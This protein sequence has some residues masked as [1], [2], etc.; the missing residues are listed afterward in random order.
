LFVCLF[1]CLFNVYECTEAALMV[2]S[3]H[4]VAG[5]LNSVQPRSLLSAPLAKGFLFI[6]CKYTSCLQMHQK[7]VSDLLIMDGCETPCG[8][9]DLN[10]GPLKEQSVFL[11]TEPS[12]QPSSNDFYEVSITAKCRGNNLNRCCQ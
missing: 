6:I 10:S 3:H 5:N 7:R 11:T 8:W 1:V 2:V 12:L 9:W 4:V